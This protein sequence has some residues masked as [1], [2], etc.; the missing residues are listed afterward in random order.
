M[1]FER[2]TRTAAFVRFACAALD[3]HPIGTIGRADPVA[4]QADAG[5]SAP[6]PCRPDRLRSSTALPPGRA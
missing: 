5:A 2:A 1:T 3:R 6:K 4:S